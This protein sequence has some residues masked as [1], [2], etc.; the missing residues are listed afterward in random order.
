[1]IKD[2]ESIKFIR[3]NFKSIG[4]IIKVEVIG[5]EKSGK[6]ILKYN[7]EPTN[8]IS[9]KNPPSVDRNNII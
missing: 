8:K 3:D 9:K 7:E 4:D 2:D 6:V 1:V 5:F